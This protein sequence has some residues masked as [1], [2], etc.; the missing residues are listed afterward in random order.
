MRGLIAGYW[1]KGGLEIYRYEK[2]KPARIAG[3]PLEKLAPVR[4]VLRKVVLVVGRDR[5]LHVRK[6]YPPASKEKLLPA[7]NVELAEMFPFV[8]PAC[9]CRVFQSVAAYTELD[10]WAWESEPYD[11]LRK[12]L[13]FSC[14][15]PEEAAFSSA[16]A[17]AFVWSREGMTHLLA[18]ADSR[19][20][21]AV[22]HPAEALTEEDVQRFLNSL[23]S[24]GTE[25]RKMRIYGTLPFP[26]QQTP[27]LV[28]SSEADRG[29]PPCLDFIPA[30][31][32]REFRAPGEIT[33]AAY[34]GLLFRVAIYGLLG[35]ALFLY[36]TTQNY[37]RAG[38]DLQVLS[39]QM[40]KRIMMVDAAKGPPATD[41]AAV[42]QELNKKLTS[43]PSP[44]TVLDLLARTLPKGSYLTTVNLNE[45]NLEVWIMS[46]E[47]LAVLKALAGEKGIRNLQ[48]QGPL[49]LEKK[50]GEYAINVT[51]EIAG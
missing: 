20:L 26:V 1:H 7:V 49:N 14:V 18:A 42:R 44:V 27:A 38:R 4:G 39:R 37:E 35:Y 31:R 40:D 21:S 23:D 34:P 51:M 25:V 22:S 19:F 36:L 45:R 47:P 13:P 24:Y 29:Y 11:L 8:K 46:R 16:A 6:R 41:Y 12:I 2:G 32:L 17:E 9:Y 3:G 10:I 5:L 43:Q 30:L 50:T 33:L 48:L 28:V 15:I